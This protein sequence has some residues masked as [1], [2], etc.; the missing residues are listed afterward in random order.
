[1]EFKGMAKKCFWILLLTALSLLMLRTGRDASKNIWIEGEPTFQ[2][3][4]A[5]LWEILE[6]IAVIVPVW[7]LSLVGLGRS[8][9]GETWFPFAEKI[10]LRATKMIMVAAGILLIGVSVAQKVYLKYTTVPYWIH[11]GVEESLGEWQSVFIWILFYGMLLYVEQWCIRRNDIRQAIRRKQLWV[12]VTI[13]LAYM[14]V[15]SIGG[16]H[17]WYIPLYYVDSPN[18]LEDYYL[19]WCSLYFAVFYVPLLF[20]AVRKT[21]R[22]FKNDGKWL[23]LSAIVPWKITVLTVLLAAGFM[24]L[25]IR[26]SY[27]WNE[28]A[29]IADVPEYG[30]AAAMGHTFQ[31]MMWGLLLVYASCLL[32]RQLRTAHRAKYAGNT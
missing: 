7:F 10:P 17:L 19:W 6:E 14:I 5:L 32:I 13:F 25:Q 3:Y 30:E 27:Y 22:L 31:A 18:T 23:T 12:V 8:V 9:L 11:D 28:W 26:E 15:S 16:V 29:E 2:Y 24:V 4:A 1:M 21:V 20:F